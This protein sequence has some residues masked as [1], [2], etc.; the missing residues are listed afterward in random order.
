MYE[1]L[2]FSL[3]VSSRIVNL[4]YLGYETILDFCLLDNETK[5]HLPW[6]SVSPFS[7]GYSQWQE[8]CLAA[9]TFNLTQISL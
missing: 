3:G 1:E 8:K 7:S 9:E 2:V 6:Q 4:A 5:K